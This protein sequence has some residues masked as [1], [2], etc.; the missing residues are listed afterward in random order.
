MATRTTN[1]HT[2]GRNMQRWMNGV[3]IKMT[4]SGLACSGLA[5]TVLTLA[6]TVEVIAQQT[7]FK[8]FLHK[9]PCPLNLM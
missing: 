3:F 5:K 7:V 1:V 2:S 8:C 9:S 6:F 4:P